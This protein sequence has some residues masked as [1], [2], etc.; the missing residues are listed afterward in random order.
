MAAWM[1]PQMG[2]SDSASKSLIS[3]H[4]WVSSATSHFLTTIL[5][6]GHCISSRNCWTISLPPPLLDSSTTVLAP[7]ST[8]YLVMDR[9]RPPVPPTITCVPSGWNIFLDTLWVA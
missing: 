8:M 4:T 5:A 7:F 1:T 6:S 9:P 3:C 2:G